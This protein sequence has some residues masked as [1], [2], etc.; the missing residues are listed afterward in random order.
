MT[1]TLSQ[2]SSENQVREWYW[3]ISIGA[4][5]FR[6]AE[7]AVVSFDPDGAGV[8]ALEVEADLSGMTRAPVSVICGYDDDLY[9]YFTGDLGKPSLDSYAGITTVEA[10]GVLGRMGRQDFGEPL[11]FQG[12]TL[13]GFFGSILALLYDPR[14]RIEVRGPNPTLEDTIMPPES[15]LREGAEAVLEGFDHV[16]RERAGFGLVVTPHPR[17][18]ALGK[19]A[20]IF[21]PADYEP[22]QPKIE[23]VGDGPYAKVIVHRRDESG[24]EVV[25]AAAK[26]TNDGAYKP[27]PNE[28]YWIHDFDGDQAAGQSTAS[29]T[30][31]ALMVDGFTGKMENATPRADLVQ[32]DPVLFERIEKVEGKNRRRQYASVLTEMEMDLVAETWSPSFSA[33]MV[34]DEEI[35]ERP[36]PAI[37]SPYVIPAEGSLHATAFGEDAEGLFFR[38]GSGEPYA[39]EDETGFYIVP[40]IDPE[41]TET[42]ADGV[43]VEVS[44]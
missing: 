27:R 9:E 16:M 28:I 6:H 22:G 10:Y 38:L 29:V 8:L 30:A 7:K 17:P 32:D 23:P 34:L 12:V 26:V 11:T 4:R 1:E 40:G 36:V 42:A 19:Y 15:A 31:R 5:T 20:A 25:W 2:T 39:G 3:E 41:A 21:G 43:S 44:E 13:R 24:N 37:L 33:L 35:R 18:A 14:L